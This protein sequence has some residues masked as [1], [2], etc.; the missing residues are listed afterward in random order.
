MRSSRARTARRR[1]GATRRSIWKRRSPRSQQIRE[2]MAEQGVDGAGAAQIAAHRTRD[3]KLALTPEEMLAR[4]REMA[5]AF[6]NQPERIVQ[7]AKE[8]MH[9]IDQSHEARLKPAQSAVTFARDRNLEREAVVDERAL[10]R[11]ALKRSM[12]QASFEEVRSHF[13]ER[14][15]EGRSDRSENGGGPI[16]HHAGNDDARTRQHRAH[17]RRARVNMRHWFSS[18]ITSSI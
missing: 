5:E 2:H 1:S 4:H 9:A 6:G 18:R 3:A 15:R 16:V 17:A 13:E 8:K 11:D 7:A 12:G 10:M 14:V